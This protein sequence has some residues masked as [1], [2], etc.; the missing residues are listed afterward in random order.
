[1]KDQQRLKLAEL[2]WQR[3]RK[4]KRSQLDERIEEIVLPNQYSFVPFSD[5]D[6]I[7]SA[8]EDRPRDKWGENLYL[9]TSTDEPGIVTKVIA[10]FIELNPYDF[11]YIFFM[12]YNF[13]FVKIDNEVLFTKWAALIELDGDE[14]YCH[15]PEKSSW[16]CIERTEDVLTAKE[17][18]G[19][20][21]I[22]EITFSNKK[23]KSDLV[24]N[25][26]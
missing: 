9:Q 22:Y 12:N 17:H 14:I 21:W 25:S 2:L 4:E 3:E 10:N 23:F 13:G 1:M 26:A 6:I 18:L 20:I 11:S 16:I 15:L 5:S 7:Q 19:R 24:K 8:S